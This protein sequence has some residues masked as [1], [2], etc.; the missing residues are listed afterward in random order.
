MAHGTNHTPGLLPQFDDLEQQR[1]SYNLGMWIFLATEVLFFGGIF[2]GYIVYRMHYGHAWH[3]ASRHL[4]MPA[5]A[6]NTIV[7]LTSSLTMALA[8]RHSQ[9]GQNRACA[10][11]LLVTMGLGIVFMCIKAFEYHH[12]YEVGNI[13]GI[14]FT[15]AGPDPGQTQLFY[16]FYFLM[17]GVHAI[18]MIIGV[19]VVAFMA[20]MSRLGRYSPGH[21]APIEMTGLYWH[22]VDI[23]WIFLFP[24]LYLMG[25]PK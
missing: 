4:I 22:F 19:C 10:R 5:G 11:L 6:I 2:M 21:H 23:V 12:E 13:P 24:L 16:V 3:E 7:L 25:Y 9:L 8:V 1:V 14:R 20:L 17:T 18:H 15:Y